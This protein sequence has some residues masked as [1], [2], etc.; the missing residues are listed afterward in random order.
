MNEKKDFALVRRPSSAVEKVAPGAKRILSGMVADTL[1][2]IN[3]GANSHFEKGEVCYKSG[4]F[5]EAFACYRKAAEQ[6]NAKA[7]NKVG[8]CF[9]FGMGI[10]EDRHEALK[11][12]GKS[13]RQGNTDSA[14]FLG[15][16]HI[17]KDYA[18]AYKWLTL[19]FE[20]DDKRAVSGLATLRSWMSPNDLLEGKRRLHEFREQTI[21]N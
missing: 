21:E 15:Q 9:H 1:A 6:G 10:T 2:L 19:A 14:C 13:T 16:W 20:Q 7:Q 3:A 11:W 18:E 17:E 12:F 5:A 4:N 8:F